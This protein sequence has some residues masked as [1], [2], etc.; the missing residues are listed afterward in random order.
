MNVVVFT[1]REIEVTVELF[2]IVVNVDVEEIML[3]TGLFSW[4]VTVVVLNTVLV[5]VLV[6]E[7]VLE[8][9]KSLVM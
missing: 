6:T 2:T 4:L 5:W 3:V 1:M 8:G 9:L 7:E